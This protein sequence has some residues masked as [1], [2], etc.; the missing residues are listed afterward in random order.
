[1]LKYKLEV[2]GTL[3]NY[4]LL[5]N[6]YVSKDDK[7]FQEVIDSNFTEFEADKN[8]GLIKKLMKLYSRV[9]ICELSNTYLTLR[10]K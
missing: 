10:Y 4:K 2:P 7:M 6:A 5:A 1:M 8:M 3:Q 9:R